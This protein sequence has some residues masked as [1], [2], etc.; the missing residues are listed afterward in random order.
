MTSIVEKLRSHWGFGLAE[1][2]KMTSIPGGVLRTKPIEEMSFEDREALV[3]LAAF[4]ELVGSYPN[5]PDPSYWLSSPIVEGYTIMREDIY[6]DSARRL[7]LMRGHLLANAA[8]K[9]TDEELLKEYNP[10]WR[11]KYWSAFTVDHDEQGVAFVRPKTRREAQ[12]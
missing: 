6:R 4:V 5:T 12:R 9:L 2:S 11:D 7:L 3:D 1:I 8:G 10:D